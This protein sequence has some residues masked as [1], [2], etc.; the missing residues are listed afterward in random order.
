MSQLTQ[1]KKWTMVDGQGA[2]LATTP[3]DGAIAVGP[4]DVVIADNDRVHWY[5]KDTSF[6]DYASLSQFF[7]D[8]FSNPGEW[9]FFDPRALYDPHNEIFVVSTAARHVDGDLDGGWAIA[10]SNT[11]NPAD[12]WWVDYI[13]EG[14]PGRWIDFPTIGIDADVIYL[15]GEV[16]RHNGTED[17]SDDLFDYAKV[18]IID[19]SRLANG[20]VYTYGRPYN[21]Q[22]PNSVL[23]DPLHTIQPAF[24][25]TEPGGDIGYAIH[26]HS[27]GA[28]HLDLIKFRNK[29]GDNTYADI[30]TMSDIPT[31]DPAPAAEQSGTADMLDPGVSATFG[32]QAYY[33]NGKLWCAHTVAHDW[34]NDGDEEGVFR[35]YKIDPANVGVMDYLSY[36]SP[37]DDFITPAVS[38]TPDRDFVITFCR[39]GEDEYPSLWTA[40]RLMSD[41]GFGLRGFQQVTG[42][43]A[44]YTGQDAS[45]I[46]RWGDYYAMSWDPSDLRQHW[47]FGQYSESSNSW[48]LDGF[49]VKFL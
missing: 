49:A 34:G 1:T 33:E 24:H 16:F 30:Y 46:N 17:E 26:A 23:D 13:P 18:L 3:P 2:G 22:E 5:N 35:Y 19:K 20:N 45:L 47:G 41:S 40:G 14:N 44:A 27:G 25:M 4:N 21:F 10:V 32:S 12:G 28:G 15:G 9:G 29:T 31:Y 7:G 11:S 39:T 48:G 38:A 8:A 37:G 6:V 42:G 36:G 43:D